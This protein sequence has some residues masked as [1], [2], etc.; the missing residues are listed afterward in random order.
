[1]ILRLIEYHSGCVIIHVMDICTF[2]NDNL[3]ECRQTTQLFL[4]C[5]I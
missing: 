3:K 2:T 5:I 1:M 4:V